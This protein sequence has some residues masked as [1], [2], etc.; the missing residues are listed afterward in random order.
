MA[1]PDRQTTSRKSMG[2]VCDNDEEGRRVWSQFCA[3]FHP[4]LIHAVYRSSRG[5]D[6]ARIDDGETR[7]PQ[8]KLWQI[9]SE[10]LGGPL[11]MFGVGA[12]T[13]LLFIT[14]RNESELELWFDFWDLLR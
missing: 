11:R 10:F 12:L 14:G 9:F 4:G 6:L 3:S 13:S 8:R 1:S 7:I 2:V 5:V